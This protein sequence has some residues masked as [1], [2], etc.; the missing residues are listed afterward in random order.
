M[1]KV[2]EGFDPLKEGL[3][4]MK[5]GIDKISDGL[6]TGSTDLGKLADASGKTSD[7]M[8][9][10]IEGLGSL[11]KGT[12]D[13]GGGLTKVSGG[14]ASLSEGLTQ[15]EAALTQTGAALTGS[16]TA[17]EQIM[18]ANTALAADQNFQ[19]VYYSIKAANDGI[20]Q[21]SAGLGQVRTNLDASKGAL[22]TINGGV[23]QIGSGLVSTQE[24]M[25]QMKTG[26]TAMQEGQ[27]K[28]AEGLKTAA[29]GL[30][31]ISDGFEPVYE[32]LDDM[33]SGLG[34][35]TD[36]SD[37]YT[38]NKNILDDVFF[39]PESILD[40]APEL[41]D[42]MKNYISDDGHGLIME[43]I[44]TV[45][46]YTNTAL[47]TVDKIKE[48][49]R[50]SIKGTSLENAEFHIGGGTGALSEVR[51]ITARDL[52]V[53]MIF[54]LSGIFIVLILLLKSLVAPV[55]LIIT[56]IFS[57]LSTMGITYLFFQ[58]LLG[59]DGLHWA[60]PFFAFCVLVA[61]GVDYNIFLMSRVKEE[62]RPGDNKGSVTRA[63]ASTGGIITSC[64]IIMAGTFGA[65]LA[66]SVRPI[67]EVGF[68]AVVGL[69]MDTFII[70]SI[71]VPAIAVKFGE[72]NW[73]PGSRI[74]AVAV[75]KKD[76]DG[77]LPGAV[78]EK[79]EEKAENLSE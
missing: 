54:V 58:K 76:K 10:T 15:S 59:Y 32:G 33:N 65:M 63:L 31:K 77:K 60:V 64:G 43:V 34:K 24:A 27:V 56:I 4:D 3:A 48:A 18:A 39:L 67:L 46:P 55:Y 38:N 25:K 40:E 35:I 52:K 13:A 17:L 49:V 20:A 5:E 74:I 7:G 62:Y 47:D 45:P 68:A 21:I 30:V 41:K 23:G 16:V 11:S 57:Y 44:L 72:V 61:L 70:R 37:T 1:L 2:Q 75:Q 42:A 79:P 29:E 28:A 6:S 22:D 50:F 9:K 12:A 8:G 78:M 19:K 36:A 51:D 66:S 71:T 53:V 69:L 73:W 14:L 26:L